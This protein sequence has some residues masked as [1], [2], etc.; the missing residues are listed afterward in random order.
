M[1]H[2]GRRSNR[3]IR[4]NSITETGFPDFRP[5]QTLEQ[6]ISKNAKLD[7]HQLVGEFQGNGST[8]LIGMSTS[9]ELDIENILRNDEKGAIIGYTPDYTHFQLFTNDGAGI[10]VATVLDNRLKDN[11]FHTFDMKITSDNKLLLRFDGAENTFTTK[12]PSISDTLYVVN[13]SIY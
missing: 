12:I 4:T 5:K 13:Y 7:A 11:E 3:G 2:S 8:V 6:D 10:K 1:A 9:Q